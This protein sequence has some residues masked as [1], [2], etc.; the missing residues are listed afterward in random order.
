M[1]MIKI[2]DSKNRRAVDA[3][4]SPE[5][6][7]DEATERRVAQIVADVRRNG[8]KALT[9][10][11]RE[12]DGL[13][14]SI[15]VS[16]D[17]MRRASRD[18][19][20]PVRAAIRTAARNIRTVARRQVP[21]GWRARVAPGV[22]VEQRVVPLDR[23]GCYVPAGRYPLPSSLL[24]TAIP[25][26]AAGVIEIVAVCPRP[27]P[28]VMAA[29]LEAGVSRMFRVGG[30]HAVAALAYGTRTVPRVDKIVGPGNR[31]VAA[32]KALVAADCGIDFYAGPTEIVIV[33]ARGSAEWIAADLI[34]QAEHDPDARAVLIT[35]SRT[36]ADRVAAQVASQMPSIGPARSAMK[37]HGG[38]IVTKS[39]DEAVSLANAAA[40]EHLVVD[41]DRMAR[42]VRCAGSLFVGPWSAQVA[43]DYAIGSNHV[44]PTAGTA[45]VRGGL[46][47]ADFVRQITVQRLTASGLNRIGRAV[48][49]L[50]NAEGLA[51]HA[52]SVAI[53]MKERQR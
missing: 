25:A 50:A 23:V 37:S 9:R 49:D 5:R 6:I 36:L 53:R 17:E 46:S 38:I 1:S 45:R 29:A 11:A 13:S 15:E 4:L 14:G 33:A 47:A 41:D 40:P 2:V 10:Y 28:V 51:A 27:A 44:L 21:R 52:A 30:A 7:R 39:V 3:L 42:R 43:G 12:L 26:D 16:I 8:D 18:V 24:M 22:T 35:P 48:V 31:Y 19:P 34:A 20:A 32:A